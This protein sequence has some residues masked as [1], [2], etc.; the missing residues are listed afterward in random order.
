MVHYSLQL[1]SVV[2]TTWGQQYKMLNPGQFLESLILDL[3]FGGRKKNLIGSL[4]WGPLSLQHDKPGSSLY[5]HYP[6]EADG[7][8]Y[9]P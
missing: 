7:A 1:R 2:D 4:T 6:D 5:S 8:L 9:F 3:E